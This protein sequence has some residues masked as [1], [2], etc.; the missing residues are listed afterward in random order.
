MI[1]V[2]KE[3]EQRPIRL[4]NYTRAESFAQWLRL[5]QMLCWHHW[6]EID[7]GDEERIAAFAD[8][9]DFAKSQ[10]EIHCATLE[11]NDEV[12]RVFRTADEAAAYEAGV[13][14]RGE[15]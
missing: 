2:L 4:P 1:A 3:I 5:N 6:S 12:A 7:D 14:A 13:P 10:Y 11:E 15:I 9:L 8:F